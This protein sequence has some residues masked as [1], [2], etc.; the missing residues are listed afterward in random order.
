M[1]I[2]EITFLIGL[3]FSGV[4]KT[5]SS[6][7]PKSFFKDWFSHGYER[8]K[9]EEAFRQT[10]ALAI[11]T[12]KKDT[13]LSATQKKDAVKAAARVIQEHRKA[14]NPK[15]KKKVQRFAGLPRGS[16][17]AM[18][19]NVG[20]RGHIPLL[21]CAWAD[22]TNKTSIGTSGHILAGKPIQR[23]TF[24]AIPREFGARVQDI[25]RRT[26][27]VPSVF[28]RLFLHLPR[29]DIHDHLR[30]G[31]LAL[32]KSWATHSWSKRVFSTLLGM[33]ITDA[34]MAF[35]LGLGDDKPSFS[36]WLNRLAY[37][38][39]HNNLDQLAQASFQSPQPGRRSSS[40]KSGSSPA[41]IKVSHEQHALLNLC[42]L[43]AFKGAAQF[44]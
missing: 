16:H 33:S 39:I 35:C 25:R 3:Y 28:E 24:K 9:T 11:A 1:Y 31:S 8:A 15:N 14:L 44:H 21:A 41:V 4:L 5:S 27:P 2:T 43:D 6:G 30:Q 20:Q 26:F 22:K 40:H 36:D 13:T 34:Y 23:T 29:I 17:L 18:T 38:L 37:Q 42:L 7:Y 32:E 19:T 12:H 10:S